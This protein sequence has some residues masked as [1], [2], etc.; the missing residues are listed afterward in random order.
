ME[1]GTRILCPSATARRHM[2]LRIRL[3]EIAA[4]L[5]VDDRLVP[6]TQSQQ[7]LLHGYRVL[8]HA[9]M[10]A[11]LESIAVTILDVTEQASRSGALTHAGHHLVV[12]WAG[13]RLQKNPGSAPYPPFLKADAIANLG[14]QPTQFQSAMKSHRASVDSNHGLRSGNVRKLLIPLGYRDSWFAPGLP[15]LLD[16]FADHRGEVAHSSGAV[17]TLAFSSGSTELK[18]TNDLLPGLRLL[19]QFVPRVL[20]PI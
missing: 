14:R 1:L 7:D 10:E 15:D 13:S 12:H 6:Q 5:G 16:A 17:G 20:R 2:E 19:E 9:E 18:R 4:S 8:A 11:F 3:N